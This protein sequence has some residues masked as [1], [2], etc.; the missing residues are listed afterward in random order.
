MTIRPIVI[1]MAL[2][3]LGACDRPPEGNS[4]A[5]QPGA[6][7]GSASS[8]ATTRTTPAEISPPASQ[9]EKTEGRNPQQGQVDPKQ[10]SQREDFQQPGDDKGPQPKT[11]N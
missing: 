1:S 11:A 8:G 4:G 5:P 10:S 9:A 6:S 7:S 3:L 2:A